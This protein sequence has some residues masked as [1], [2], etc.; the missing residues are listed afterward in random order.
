MRTLFFFLLIN[1][2]ENK[3]VGMVAHELDFFFLLSFPQGCPD[4]RYM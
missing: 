3:E 4:F 2:G 1:L